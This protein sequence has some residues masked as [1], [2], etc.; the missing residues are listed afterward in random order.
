MLAN[1]PDAYVL[2]RAANLHIPARV[3]NREEFTSPE[4]SQRLLK[5]GITHVVLAGF[6]WLAPQHLVAAFPNRI[7][8]IHPA[9]LPK[10][11]GKGM[12]GSKVHEA[13]VTSGEKETGIT[14]HL[15][16]E[17]YDKGV[18][19]L[20]VSCPVT[21]EDTA[22]MVAAKVHELEYQHFPRTIENWIIQTQS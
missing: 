17:E 5:E 8:N 4:F 19:L 3:F 12:Y 1:K 18:P 15:V 22:D 10:F 16:N 11:G 6:L 14:I 13:V 7:V 2:E 9:L 21:T 20:Q